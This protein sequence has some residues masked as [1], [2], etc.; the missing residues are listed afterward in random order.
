MADNQLVLAFFENEE[1]ADQAA[2]ALKAWDK[3]SD[4]IK[5]GNVGVLVKG[6]DGQVKEQKLGPRSGKKGAGIGLVLGILAVP[7]TAGLSLLGGAVGGAVGGGI[8][9]SL[10]QKGLPKE[11]VE[12]IGAELAAGRAAV[13]VLAD[14]D[15]VAQVTAKLT[16]LGGTPEAHSVSD[17][18]LQ[19]AAAT[20]GSDDATAAAT[21]A[22]DSPTAETMS[23]AAADTATAAEQA[24]PAGSE[25]S[26][27]AT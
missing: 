1:A 26:E 27:S 25:A 4:E 11:D 24:P 21:T 18:G 5:L 3:A 23:T 6:E 15:E 22:A 16:E 20:A 10:F 12:R 14:E 17:E 2:E 9:G 7:F 8:I 19:Q 13:G